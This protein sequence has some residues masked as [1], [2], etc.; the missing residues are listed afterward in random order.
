MIVFAMFSKVPFHILDA[1]LR[2]L[3]LVLDIDIFSA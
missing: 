2:H 1:F 3:A